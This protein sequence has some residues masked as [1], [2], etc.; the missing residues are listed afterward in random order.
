MPR[1]EYYLL[2]FYEGKDATGA[3]QAADALSL[4][5]GAGTICEMDGGYA[6]YACAYENYKDAEGVQKRIREAGGKCTVKPFTLPAL[7][8]FKK[9]EQN[10]SMLLIEECFSVCFSAFTKAYKDAEAGKERALIYG[11]IS[12]VRE[13][14]FA[15]Q[16]ALSKAASMLKESAFFHKANAFMADCEGFCEALL[17]ESTLAALSLNAKRCQLSLLFAYRTAL[18]ALSAG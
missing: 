13:K 2:C 4:R 6:V 14:A 5:G 10:Q 16:K 9:E 18:V 11:E 8:A 15:L 7:S 12:A 17:A 3:K 1:R